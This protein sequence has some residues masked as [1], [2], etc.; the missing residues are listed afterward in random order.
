MQRRVPA[1]IH[2]VRQGE[3][4]RGQEELAH[5]LVTAHGRCVQRRAPITICGVSGVKPP[6]CSKQLLADCDMAARR[7]P[8]QRRQALLVGG[9]HC[10]ELLRPEE[11]RA[12]FVVPLPCGDVQSCVTLRVQS[13]RALEIWRR[14][15][16]L[17][18]GVV[19]LVGRPMERGAALAIL[20]G[21][22]QGMPGDD[23]VG[24]PAQQRQLC[25]V[26]GARDRRGQHN[27]HV[28]RWRWRLHQGY[29]LLNGRLCGRL[30]QLVPHS[31]LHLPRTRRIRCPLQ[32]LR[33]GVLEMHYLG[34]GTGGC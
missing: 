29:V 26:R 10:H 15:Q 17:A 16:E 33:H 8:V 19:A 21:A 18:D 3:P 4:R 24:A 1:H 2:C 5:R 7:G 28:R 27:H 6:L 13:A 22:E 23:R 9:T 12:A 30:G 34:L 20:G 31:C 32:A 25:Q 11:V 14:Q